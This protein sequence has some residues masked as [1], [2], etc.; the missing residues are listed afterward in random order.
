MGKDKTKD[1]ETTTFKTN[2]PWDACQD[3]HQ[4]L[5][6]DHEARD[7]T[8]VQTITEAVTREIAKAH[9][10]YQAILNERVQP[11]FKPTLKY[12]Q[13]QMVLRL[14]TPSIGQRT[15]LSAKDGNCG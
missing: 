10:H 7:A 15:N 5:S 1:G 12:L 11:P 3:S 4:D 2:S 6:Q 9:A 8:L 14:W 13:E